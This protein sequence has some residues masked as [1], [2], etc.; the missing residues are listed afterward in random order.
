MPCQLDFHIIHKLI[1]QTRQKPIPNIHPIT[2]L[3][4]TRMSPKSMGVG[5]PAIID[6]VFELI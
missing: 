1:E 2:R 6:I 4:I 5:N 3:N